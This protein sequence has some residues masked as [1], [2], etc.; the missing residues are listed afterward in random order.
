M[1]S[2]FDEKLIFHTFV[3]SIYNK[4]HFYIAVL[5]LITIC[6]SLTINPTCPI[7]FWQTG[8]KKRCVKTE[9]EGISK[10]LWGI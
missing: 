7:I 9:D 6:I 10:Y 1:K 5:V 2:K 4:R 3:G 8:K